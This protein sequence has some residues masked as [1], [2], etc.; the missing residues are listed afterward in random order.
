MRRLYEVWEE[1]R[2][3]RLSLGVIYMRFGKCMGIGDPKGS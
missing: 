2:D 1:Y 3:P